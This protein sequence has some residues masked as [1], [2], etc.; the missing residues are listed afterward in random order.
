V[1]EID[2]FLLMNIAENPEVVKDPHVSALLRE[3]GFSQELL[4]KIG[5]SEETE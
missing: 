2:P 3:M 5:G 1:S 4:D